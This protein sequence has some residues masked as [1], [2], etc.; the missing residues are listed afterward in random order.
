MQI[1]LVGLCHDV[2]I[3]GGT[4]NKS[5]FIKELENQNSHFSWR[6]LDLNVDKS[7]F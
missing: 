7:I 3:I 2:E 4:R 1:I 6:Q 5:Q